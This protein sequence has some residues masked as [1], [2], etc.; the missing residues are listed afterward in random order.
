MRHLKDP[1]RAL[2]TKKVQA[3][4]LVLAPL[5]I[6]LVFGVVR[7]GVATEMRP[8]SGSLNNPPEAPQHVMKPRSGI[9]DGC[10][11]E[12]SDSPGI[13]PIKYSATL[14]CTTADGDRSGRRLVVFFGT[15]PETIKMA[16]I[17]HLLTET[18]D[19]NFKAVFTGQLVAPFAKFWKLKVDT[20]VT[21][22]F[23][24]NQTLAMLSGSLI[25]EV[26]KA[27]VPCPN[28]V[29]LVQGDTTSAFAVGIVAFLRGTPV[30]HVEAGLRTFDMRSPFPEE[31]NRRAI[32]LMANIHA[33]PTLLS[34]ENLVDQGVD[35]AL[36][37]VTGNTGIDAAR[38]AEPLIV[39]PCGVPESNR[40]L[41]I[42]MHRREN[43]D[44]MTEMYG[45]LRPYFP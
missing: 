22:T 7:L 41:Y 1:V 36:I 10:L 8:Q 5:M 30:I 11:P 32:G 9:I 18:N 3:V 25:R 20:H 21:G 28:D 43:R 34:R 29:W 13:S 31:F 14:S 19:T 24:A 40:T 44:R 23:T 39:K 4:L 6:F 2:S 35:P 37:S 15:R 16:P 33:A 45:N 38:L 27:I 12:T 26:D 17:L 42:T